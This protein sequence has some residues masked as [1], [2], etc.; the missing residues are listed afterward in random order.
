MSTGFVLFMIC[1]ECIY[2]INLRHAYLLSPNY[3]KRLSARTVLF[4]CIPKQYLEEAKL[5]KLFGDSAK[6]VWIPR[7]TRFLRGLVEDRE[8][9]AELLEQAEIRLIRMANRA[10]NRHLKKHPAQLVPVQP[11]SSA[12]SPEQRD[13]GQHDAD[14]EKG[15][16]DSTIRFAQ[17]Q[18]SVLDDPATEKP[19]D[20][21]YTHPYG[22]DPSLPDVRGSVASLW[23]PAEKRPHH[24]PLTNFGRRVDTI[25]W[26]RARIKAL[27]RDIWKLRRKHRGGDGAPLSAAFI[28]FDTQVNA[29]AAYQI[30]AHHQPLHMSP[31]FIGIRP[32]EIIW[33]SLRMKWWEQIMRRFFML[34]FIAVAIIFWS[35]PSAFVGTISNIDSLVDM[36]KFLS[37]IQK[38]PGP[39][40]GVIKG[41]L[42]ALALSWLMAAVPM[43]LRG[44]L[45]QGSLWRA[46]L[47]YLPSLRKSGRRHL[48]CSC[49]ALRPECILCVPDRTS[50]PRHNPYR[51]SVRRHPGHHQ[52]PALHHGPSLPESAQGLQLL[53]FVHSCPVSG[54]GLRK[55]RQFL[56]PLPPPD[57][58]QRHH[59][60]QEALLSM[61]EADADS[62]GCRVSSVH[63]HGR[64]W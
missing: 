49:G 10:R 13:S 6:N 42:P 32:E 58:R 25:R 4:T 2:Y 31:R 3:S 63:Q 5:R 17:R 57:P 9:A 29:Q 8:N 30:L 24:R 43:M 38:L 18:L 64:H 23:L 7:N 20:P 54:C 37:F 36:F 39:I 15:K 14:A 61:A 11:E 35:I 55:S 60:S 22:L 27:N 33:S 47:T 45:H 19:Q 44:K 53:S 50:I 26:T 52:E 28:E 46:S 21:E 62:L 1:R 41:L 12:A 16:A 59:Q 51:S 40:L 34:G 48:S 56:R